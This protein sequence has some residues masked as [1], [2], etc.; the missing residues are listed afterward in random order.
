MD[1][2][3]LIKNAG[4]AGVLAAGIAP[5]VHAQAAVRW[6]LASSFPKSLDTIFGTAETFSKKVSDITGGKFQI[7]VHAS[8]EL[9]PALGVL[10]GVQNASVEMAHTAPYYFYGKDPTF[11]L[12]CAVPFGMN[13]RQMNA[14]MYE[15]NGLKLMREF[16]AKYNVFSLP[17]GNTGAQMGGWFRKEIKSVAD[18]KGLKFR[19]NPI[20]GKVLEP[21]GMIPQ[22]IPGAD[23]Y[24]ALEKGT[25]DALEWVGPYDDQKLGF[26]K[27]APFYYYPGWWE[28]G[29]QLDF[30]INSKAWEGL[31]AE[32]KA[33]VE[34]AAAHAHVTMTAK[35]DAK[36]PIA[37]KQLVG[38]GTKLR[39]FTQDVMNA[40]FKS[41]QQIYADLNNSNPE[42]KKVY[43]DYAKFLADQNAWFRFTEGT[44]DRFMQQQKL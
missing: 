28:G 11:A 21:F 31:S 34:V 39:P 12:G 41:A 16:Y 25:I 26:N 22:S 1:R 37:L 10:D 35:Y 18:L 40:A 23:L 17:G 4:I 44:Y 29:P 14:W 6:R 5:A 43:T 9:M 38:S 3:S 27:V 19:T 32:Y 42:W 24:P 36:N 7:S 30:Y 13:T 20:A 33:V 2:R 8:G 15:G